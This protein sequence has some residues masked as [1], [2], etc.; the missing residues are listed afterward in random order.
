MKGFFHQDK[1]IVGIIAG[2]GSELLLALLLTIGLVI[3]GEAPIAHIRWYAGVFVAPLLLLRY[4][5]KQK[6]W[7]RV[8]RTLIVVLFVTFVAFMFYLLKAHLIVYK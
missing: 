4:Y 7:L 2:V 1:V 8:T 3:A 6:S 5:S